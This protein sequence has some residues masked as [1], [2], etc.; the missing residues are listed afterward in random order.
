MNWL[1]R[2]L[3][4]PQWLALLLVLLA[5]NLTVRAVFPQVPS[6][7]AGNSTSFTS[8]LARLPEPWVSFVPLA[9]LGLF[10]VDHAIEF[11]L[12]L[13]LLG[14]SLTIRLITSILETKKPAQIPLLPFQKALHRE[15]IPEYITD[16]LAR[17]ESKLLRERWQITHMTGPEPEISLLY[18]RR[19]GWACWWLVFLYLGGLIFLLGLLASALW[20]W[21]TESPA[22]VAG[23]S[24]Q[25]P[26]PA[27]PLNLR[28]QA[29][30]DSAAELAFSNEQDWLL[31]LQLNRSVLYAGHWY[32]LSRVGPAVKVAALDTTEHPLVIKPYGEPDNRPAGTP[33]ALTFLFPRSQRYAFIPE[34]EL[35]LRLDYYPSLPE[36]GIEEPV[37]LAQVYQRGGRTLLSD[38]V[39]GKEVDWRVDDVHLKLQPDHFAIVQV[40]Y[41]P[42]L[43]LTLVGAAIIV[44]ALLGWLVFHPAQLWLAAVTAQPGNPDAGGVVEMAVVGEAIERLIAGTRQR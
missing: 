6:A 5:L 36:H 15:V 37:F 44:V 2:L 13:A 25:I 19:R 17:L 27:Q 20:A 29:I 42:G 10:D 4:S 11:R 18:A 21:Q 26:S 1:W 7:L 32:R 30:T 16:W 33:L 38:F 41:E 3:C 40:S 39:R 43:T 22:L 31:S 9:N 28:L 8:W 35:T 23:Q 12:L 14:W 24:W 34:Y